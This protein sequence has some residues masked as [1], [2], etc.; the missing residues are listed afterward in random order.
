MIAE[1][2]PRRAYYT[3]LTQGYLVTFSFERSAFHVR[4]NRY[5]LLEA[6]VSPDTDLDQGVVRTDH[7]FGADLQRRT[8]RV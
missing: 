1:S 4:R 8:R 5:S 7:R 2:H 3:V 6:Y